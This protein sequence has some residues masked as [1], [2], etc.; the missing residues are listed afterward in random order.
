MATTTTLAPSAAPFVGSGSRRIIDS[1][2][3][4]NILNRRVLI[5]TTDVG[6]QLVL[7]VQ[8]D[9]QLLPQGYEYTGRAGKTENM[10]DRR[11]YN[12]QASSA[13]SM[14]R[15]EN[16]RIL[17][18]AL[19][20]KAAGDTELAT[21]KFNAYLNAI[22]VSFSVII[23]P[24]VAERRFANGDQIKG[25]VALVDTK[26]GEKQ[27][28]LESVSLKPAVVKE[29]TKFAISDLLGEEELAELGSDDEAAE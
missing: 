7:T 3:F 22:Q 27:L 9:G 20:A 12:V 5:A 4:T 18:E 14:A 29:R 24:G 13:L 23:N 19:K 6:S 1:K 2:A 17:A 28:V 11:I 16:R 21:D 25:T 26:A 8:G 15:K 10:F